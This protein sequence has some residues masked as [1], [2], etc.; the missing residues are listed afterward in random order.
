MKTNDKTWESLIKEINNQL[1]IMYD[2][3][4]SCDYIIAKNNISL[5]AA[6]KLFKPRNV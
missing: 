4:E 1:K 5:A 2:A 6:N 3:L